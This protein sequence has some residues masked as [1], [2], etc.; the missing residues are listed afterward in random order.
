MI[1]V[2]TFTTLFPNT[3]Q[4]QHGVFVENRLRELLGTGEI[5][6]RVLAPIPWFPFDH[7]RFGR[8]AGY[9]AAPRDEI[10]DGVRVAHPRY[11]VIPK[12][13]PNLAP[14]S[15]YQ[16]AARTIAGWQRQGYAFDLIDSHFFFPDGIAAILLGLRFGKPVA[17]TA[18]APTST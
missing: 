7:P 12:V 1:R 17:I 10:R 5:E 6:A 11:P 18:R 16:A 4:P 8:Y 14:F 2:L 15:L 3:A 9:A 13:G